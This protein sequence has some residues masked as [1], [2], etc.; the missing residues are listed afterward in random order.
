[1]AYRNQHIDIKI[2]QGPRHHVVV[3]DTMKITFNQQTKR[4]LLLTI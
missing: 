1:M 4:I 2:P 3:P